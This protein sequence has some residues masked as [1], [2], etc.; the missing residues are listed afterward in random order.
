MMAF[1]ALV[2]ALSCDDNV[3]PKPD[4]RA[5]D[6]A[7]VDA[8][9]G[10]CPG[11]FPFVGPDCCDSRGQRLG[12]AECS[13]STWQCEAPGSL[14]L[15][16]GRAQDSGC[17]DACGSDAFDSLQCEG[18]AWVCGPGMIKTS[19]CPPGTCWGDPGPCC[20]EGGNPVNLVCQDGKWRWV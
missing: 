3:S 13:G 14:C 6:G 2:T 17:T 8:T 18:N 10:G 15:C 1:A 5:A 4:A 19:D 12:S 7:P 11:S 20:D 16:Q 9:Q